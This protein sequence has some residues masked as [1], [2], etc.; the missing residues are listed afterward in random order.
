VEPVAEAVGAGQNAI[1]FLD[2]S[3]R[4]TAAHPRGTRDEGAPRGCASGGAGMTQR[5]DTAQHRIHEAAAAR[6]KWTAG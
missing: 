1:H 6:S 4:H 3:F 2:E 5:A